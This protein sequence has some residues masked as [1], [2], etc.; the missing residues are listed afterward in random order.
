MP[1]LTILLETLGIAEG[2]RASASTERMIKIMGPF[3]GYFSL[4]VTHNPQIIPFPFRKDLLKP[5]HNFF[6]EVIEYTRCACG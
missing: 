5:L 1:G 6:I 4:A 2:G 3:I